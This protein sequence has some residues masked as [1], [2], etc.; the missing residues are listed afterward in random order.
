M[1]VERKFRNKNHFEYSFYIQHFRDEKVDPQLLLELARKQ[2]SSNGTKTPAH[3]QRLSDFL[4][5]IIYNHT[6]ANSKEEVVHNQV[7]N[8]A[9]DYINE[10]LGTAYK[11]FELGSFKELSMDE[12][13]N[14][15]K[16]AAHYYDQKSHKLRVEKQGLID[17]LNHVNDLIKKVESG[18]YNGQIS[19]QDLNTVTHNLTELQ[20]IYT[21]TIEEYIGKDWAK[22]MPNHKSK[23]YF[24][25][26]KEKAGF[27]ELMDTA[28]NLLSEIIYIGDASIMDAGGDKKNNANLKGSVFELILQALSD[29]DLTSA[30]E[31]YLAEQINNNFKKPSAGQNTIQAFITDD[32]SFNPIQKTA[33]K[34]NK[35]TGEM[36]AVTKEVIQVAGNTWK[37]DLIKNP[38]TKGAGKYGKVDVEF[39]L[40]GPE[41]SHFKMSAKNWKQYDEAHYFGANLYNSLIYTSG[42][43]RTISWVTQIGWGSEN[44]THD[45]YDK[46]YPADHFAKIAIILNAIMGYGQAHSW[47]DTLIINNQA[48]GRVDVYSISDILDDLEDK[49]A[50]NELVF[51]ADGA[52]GA[53]N[54]FF[55]DSGVYKKI[56]HT[57]S[58]IYSKRVRYSVPKLLE[59]MQEINIRLKITQ[60]QA[61]L[62]SFKSK[63]E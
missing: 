30:T 9:R 48:K 45:T 59:R 54:N 51:N 37:A 14:L 34:K 61:S 22:R 36:E 7:M 27:K 19:E 29:I 1:D 42:L 55:P 6:Q 31:D 15:L 50:L 52:G 17:R 63:A 3:Y 58:E 57:R 44:S 13:K 28:D 33:M 24:E 43:H 11:K 26:D 10:Q 53:T 8:L 35:E 56:F 39:T 60:L 46:Y 4:N 49:T 41:P 25:F 20:K 32:G 47:T 12:R 18:A 5:T 38:Y 21:T 40:P 16:E 2:I 62:P 23:T